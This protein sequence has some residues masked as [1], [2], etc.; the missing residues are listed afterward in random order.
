MSEDKFRYQLGGLKWLYEMEL[1]DDPQF[2][3]SFKQQI[4]SVSDHI[5]EVEFVASYHTK[6]ILV[7]LELGWWGRT[8]LT[9][10]ITL[11]VLEHVQRL[12]PNFEFRVVTDR[13]IL[14]L[15][16]EKMQNVIKGV[17]S[18]VSSNSDTTE[19][20]TSDG[21]SEDG[22]QEAS[23]LLPDQKEPSDAK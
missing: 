22:L 8:F 21:S 19:P 7:W 1:V 6:Q 15:S 3:N 4:F 5:R 16:V 12:L 9:Q 14:D 13:A 23:D 17:N 10:R 20:A 2:V 18:E 11:D